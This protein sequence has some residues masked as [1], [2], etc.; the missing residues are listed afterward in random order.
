[1]PRHPLVPTTQLVKFSLDDNT[2]APTAPD[3][4]PIFVGSTAKRTTNFRVRAMSFYSA[5]LADGLHNV[6][7]LT[8]SDYGDATI[9][10]KDA[11]GNVVSDPDQ[12]ETVVRTVLDWEP[13]YNYEIISGRIDIPSDLR[14]GMTDL[15]YVSAIGVPDYPP[16][17][18]GSIP[19]INDVNV[20]A[21]TTQQVQADGRAISYMPY[22]LNGIPGTNKLRF[23]IKHPAGVRQ[24]FQLLIEHYV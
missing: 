9:T 8:D 6:N 22:C 1:M 24:R 12:L 23:T 18:Y 7:P 19:F 5:R 15:W 13:H 11:Q 16:E 10:L 3:G 4:R 2:P 21:I 20:E 14:D 17:Y